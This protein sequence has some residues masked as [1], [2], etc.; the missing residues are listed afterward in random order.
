[1]TFHALRALTAVLL[2][3]TFAPGAWAQVTII[4][5][6]RVA[7]LATAAGNANAEN[8]AAGL[9]Q[10][11][12]AV[13]GDPSSAIINS[14]VASSQ[15]TFGMNWSSQSNPGGA[16]PG[17]VAQMQV[18]FSVASATQLNFSR[19]NAG[20]ASS[21]LTIAD[22]LGGTIVSPGQ[23]DGS[24]TVSTG[25]YTLTYL[26]TC[27][28]LASGNN[29]FTITFG[30]PPPPPASPF[31]F[32]YQGRV[33]FGGASPPARLDV[34]YAFFT[35]DTGATQTPGLSGGTINSVT[36][37]ADG[38]INLLL[39]PGA[40]FPA[41]PVHLEL[42]VRPEGGG[43]F[44]TL[45]PRTLITPT[46]KATFA[47]NAQQAQIAQN[48]LG[49]SSTERVFLGGSLSDL[50]NSPG[51]WLRGVPTNT[52][53]AF[54]GLR[55]PNNAGLFGRFSG[56]SFVMNSSTGYVGI[57][58]GYN[59]ANISPQFEVD[60]R[61]DS[62]TQLALT[63]SNGGRTWSLQSSQG[64]YGSGS[65]FNGAFQI[66][67]RTV[68]AARMLIDTNG[69]TGVGTTTPVQRLDVAGN[70]RA[71]ALVYSAPV[72]SHVSIGDAAWRPRQGSTSVSGVGLGNGG[73]SLTSGDQF[74]A[75]AEL[76]LPN[77]ATIQSITC[78][79]TD[80]DAAQDL[81]F[82]LL[83]NNYNSYLFTNGLG[84]SSGAAANAR[85]FS[86]AAVAGT[87]INNASNYYQILCTPVGS[88][89]GQWT[90]NLAIRGV[91]VTYTLPG[92]GH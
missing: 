65:Q 3:L 77:G 57:G 35:T 12:L 58:R 10:P 45:S 23:P 43:P 87:V 52:D 19:S 55:D 83:I 68:G 24:T 92:P 33:N 69:N 17:A 20:P 86:S 15:I 84:S 41:D 81:N 31:A 91:V 18:Q 63:S 29:S 14:N 37:P 47:I 62:D 22:S 39:D 76:H 26:L 89:F 5:S 90:P 51:L 80:N 2:L 85:S 8:F 34:Q 44:T 59:D 53:I 67:D 78:H 9:W 6:S 66:V 50:N 1:M 61:S 82:R 28:V 49:L 32:T 42:R 36:R 46:P 7:A 13:P 64:N 71:N 16:L 27:P 54:F 74:G 38:L 79:F 56:W 40:P 70:V 75:V 73:V 21:A 48:A 30:A 60:V 88:P 72:T 4:S 25:T 11:T